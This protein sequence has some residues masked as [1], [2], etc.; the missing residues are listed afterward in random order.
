M[1]SDDLEPRKAIEKPKD[2]D[3]LGIDGLEEYLGELKAEVARVEA[4]IAAKQAYKSGAEAFF[5]S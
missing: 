2:L 5:K 3:S 4:K 1:D